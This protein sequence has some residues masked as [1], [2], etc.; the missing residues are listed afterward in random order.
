MA[1]E[2]EPSR[3]DRRELAPLRGSV[4]EALTLAQLL[5]E[6]VVEGLRE[7]ADRLPETIEQEAIEV[8]EELR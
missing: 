6:K 3:G 5:L 8:D 4:V 1:G 7:Y 2:L